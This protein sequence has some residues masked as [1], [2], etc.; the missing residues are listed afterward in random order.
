M[1]LLNPPAE[2]IMPPL[3]RIGAGAG[4]PLTTLLGASGGELDHFDY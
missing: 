2:P 3:G 4:T 1:S